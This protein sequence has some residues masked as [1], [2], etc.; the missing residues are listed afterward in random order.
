MFN[1]TGNA[2]PLPSWL[3]S[4]CSQLNLTPHLPAYFVLFG[5]FSST[6]FA[7]CWGTLFWFSESRTTPVDDRLLGIQWAGGVKQKAA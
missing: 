5:G 7:Y 1:V 6:L 4:Q 3:L 2:T